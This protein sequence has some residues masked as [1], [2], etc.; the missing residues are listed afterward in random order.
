MRSPILA[1][2]FQRAISA[3]AR[4]DQQ[5]VHLPAYADLFILGE[6]V[7]REVVAAG[8][9][10]AGQR[11]PQPPVRAA[12]LCDTSGVDRVAVALVDSV[13]VE[14]RERVADVLLVQL[15]D[16]QLRDEQLGER[17]RVGFQ[18]E[19]R[20]DGDLMR[21]LE[22]A[23]E[24]VHLTFVP[25]VEEQQASVPCSALNATCGS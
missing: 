13:S 1:R 5:S 15:G 24:D 21:H 2:S 20:G 18:L 25:V 6:I 14:Q 3:R 7:L 9:E 19:T 16:L 22:A 12:H 17:Q 4:S 8:G 10:I 23:H 11:A